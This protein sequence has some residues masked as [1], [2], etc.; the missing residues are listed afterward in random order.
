M[1]GAQRAGAGGRDE[2]GH[3]ARLEELEQLYQHAPVGICLVDRDCRYVQANQ[4]YAKVVGYAIPDLIG[5]LMRDVIPASARDRAVSAAQQVMDTGEAL[6]DL[7]LRRFTTDAPGE[8]RIWL[9][10]IHPV[11]HD[12][13]VS[14][15]MAVLQN[16]TSVRKAEEEA[17][18]R[19]NELEAIYRNAPVG[20][21]FLDR[22]LRYLRANQIIAD[23]AGLTIEE[24]VG[25]T[26]RDLSPDTAATAEP[27]LRRIMEEGGSLRNVEVRS[28]PPSDPER[29]H[30]FQLSVDPVRDAAGEIVGHTSSVQDVTELQRIEEAAAQRLRQLEIL[31]AHTPI[32][33]C[34]M[35]PD[36]RI[37][38]LNPLFAQ[39]S[40][41]PREE[42]VGAAAPELMPMAIGAQILPHLLYAIRSGVASLRVEVRGQRPGSDSREYTWLADAHPVRG[43]DGAITGVIS[44]LQ[45]VTVLAARQRELE[46]V[47]DRLVE[48][49]R[50]ARV[51]SWEW[52]ILND[53]IW[54]S[55]HLHEIFGEGATLAPSFTKLVERIHPDDRQKFRSQIER[56]LQDDRPYRET[57]RVVRDD[58]SERIIFAA[59]RL[60]RTP[61]GHP[62][63]MIGTSQDVTAF[64]P[65][66][67]GGPK[68]PE[69]G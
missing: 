47:R 45:D 26:Y 28:R 4:A 19:L 35:D 52:D 40:H 24:V 3:G 1:S 51:G 54:W 64:G 56:T 7:E 20:L 46:S 33:L 9:V 8:D 58:G 10:N 6:I 69:G 5:R 38:H 29:E 63:R 66:A 16:I 61:D 68:T 30:V 31:Y 59:A 49:Q 55:E 65:V 41:L 12:G 37:V 25:K 2:A 43:A 18:E 48:A 15:A 11:R 32:G 42:Q 53:T 60:V 14:G 23:I 62:A 17:R 57:F 36:L 44:V 21:C 50:V 27:L 34:F 13:R 67:T 39:L 22:D